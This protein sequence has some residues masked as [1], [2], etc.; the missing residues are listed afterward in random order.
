LPT[1]RTGV[2]VRSAHWL[3]S[4]RVFRRVVDA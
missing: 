1:E 4:N 2:S 3:A